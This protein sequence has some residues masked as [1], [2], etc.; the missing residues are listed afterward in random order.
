MKCLNHLKPFF[1][2]S[3]IVSAFFVAPVGAQTAAELSQRSRHALNQL[4]AQN[5]AAA[6]L[7]RSAVGI[8][9]F[10]DILK[11]GFIFGA[12]H[13]EGALFEGGRAVR[14][15]RTSAASYGFQAGVQKFGYALF[16]MNSGDLNYLHKTDGWE[17]GSGPS[18]VIV[19]QG[20]ARTLSTT[21][22]QKGV[23][24][25]TFDQ[26][27]LMAGLGL[28]GSKITPYTPH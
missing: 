8:L 20:M 17:F 15:Y 18:I 1:L 4:C 22:L 13:G 5:P 28:Q 26:Q 7:R 12:Q 21:T 19:D 16:L 9:V 23:Y 6:R 25:F 24:A 11:A 3:V 10:P 27:G 2:L 14:Y